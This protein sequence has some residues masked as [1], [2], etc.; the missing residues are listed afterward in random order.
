MVKLIS[1][2]KSPNPKKKLRATFYIPSQDTYQYIDFGAVDFEDYTTHKDKTRRQRYIER[3]QKNENWNLPLTAGT[4]S[5]YIL[6]GDYT[7]LNKNIAAY[8]KKFHL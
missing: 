7:D 8:K 5:R 2:D 3:H 6:W 1:V 4:L